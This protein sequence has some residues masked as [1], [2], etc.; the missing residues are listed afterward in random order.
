MKKS[1]D[2]RKLKMNKYQKALWNIIQSLNEYSPTDNYGQDLNIIQEIVDKGNTMK[3]LII[4][5]ADLFYII[6]VLNCC[7]LLLR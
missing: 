5:R 6:I 2:W 3:V 1:R 4:D 7:T